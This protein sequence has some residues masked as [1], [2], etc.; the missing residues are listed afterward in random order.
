MYWR[1]NRKSGSPIPKIVSPP[2]F[3][4]RFGVYSPRKVPEMARNVLKFTIIRKIRDNNHRGQTGNR[5]AKPEVV[6][7]FGL[8]LV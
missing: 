3:Y 1:S 6:V 8:L 5:F 4:F 7:Y 2:Y